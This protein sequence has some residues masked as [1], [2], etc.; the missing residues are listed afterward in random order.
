MN[1]KR[2]LLA[3]LAV[4]VVRTALN[5]VFYGMLMGETYRSA[6]AGHEDMFREVV[7]AFIC[8]DLFFA[9]FFVYLFTKVSHCLGGG[10][11]GG[12]TLAVFLVLL[13]PVLWNVYN[14]FSVTY[15]P[16]NLVVIDI[17]YALASYCIVGA[18]AGAVYK[19]S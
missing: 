14:F 4:F 8:A 19:E 18:V 3:V 15:L 7:P 12:V 17:V 1:T 5:A 6:I 10:V 13:G 9:I 16:V 11:K 2:C